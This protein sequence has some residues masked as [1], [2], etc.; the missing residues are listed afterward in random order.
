M[1]DVVGG[2]GSRLNRTVTS[3][4]FSGSLWVEFRRSGR[5]DWNATSV[6]Y[7]HANK[8]VAWTRHKRIV[9]VDVGENNTDSIRYTYTGKPSAPALDSTRYPD[10]P[11]AEAVQPLRCKFGDK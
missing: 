10:G 6:R 3:S 1:C 5:L 8:I 11:T 4:A 2:V 7:G 9:T